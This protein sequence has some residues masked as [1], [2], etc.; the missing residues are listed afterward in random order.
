MR[1]AVEGLG[2]FSDV[3]LTDEQEGFLTKVTAETPD[4]TMAAALVSILDQQLA[5]W[6]DEGN[7]D[8]QGE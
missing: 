6:L 3:T 4:A 2:H 7:E 8:G 1:I 5:A